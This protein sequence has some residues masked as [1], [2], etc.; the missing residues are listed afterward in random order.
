MPGTVH[1][2]GAGVSGLAA[3][4]R[5]ASS[6]RTVAVHEATSQAGGRCRSYHDPALDMTI[7]NGN[8]LVLSGN[9]AVL[10][11]LDAIGT[12][13][14]LVG[15][16]TARFP[17]IDLKT[18]VRWTLRANDGRMP[19]WIFDPGRR[20]PRTS[21]VDYLSLLRLLR[22]GPNAAI[23]DVMKCS[24]VLYE[25]LVGPLLL[26]ALNTEPPLGSA[27]LAAAV[28]RETLAAGGRSY[29]PLIARDGLS[30]A[31]IDP[32]LR[33]IERSGGTIAFGHRLHALTYKPDRV[34]ALDFG[35]EPVPLAA[36][37]AVVL[38]VP[39]VV[40]ASVVP[41]PA[42]ADSVPRHRQRPFPHRAA[43][44]RRGYHR[45]HQ[46]HGRM[47]FRLSRPPLGHYQLRRSVARRS[48]RGTR[49][50]G[51]G[52][53]CDDHGHCGSAAAMADRAGTAGDVC[54]LAGGEC[55]T[56]GRRDPL[57]QPVSRRRLDGDRPAGNDRG[58][59][60]LR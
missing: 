43:G 4:V 29:R 45:R 5:L 54:R 9:R 58:C 38:A 22:A 46:R 52:R 53:G 49:R 10:D 3:A 17:F 15:P 44:R 30:A 23:G 26:A 20:V 55:Q 50:A 7:D 25:R 33:F 14:Q 19:W 31:L 39:P 41:R 28:I 1:I 2:I 36:D 6:G 57:E 12:R 21:A 13:D 60:P 35:E 18:G 24:G 11:Y 48:A 16:E 56:S 37:D 51:L 59:D 42:D 32:A 34:M 40:A 8:H 47:A 27:A